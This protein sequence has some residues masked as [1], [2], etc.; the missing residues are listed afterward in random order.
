[1]NTIPKVQKVNS[2]FLKELKRAPRITT[3]AEHFENIASGKSLKPQI[4]VEA[5]LALLYHDKL[6]ISIYHYLKDKYCKFNEHCYASIPYVLENGIRIMAATH[7]YALYLKNNKNEEDF[8]IFEAGG[9]AGDI[10][11]TL[12]EISQGFI[13][14]LCSSATKANE[15][16]FNK[17]KTHLNSFFYF[18]PYFEITPELLKNSEKYSCFKNGFNLI[19]ERCT[20]QMYS[21]DRVN[22]IRILARVLKQDGIILFEEKLINKDLNEYVKGERIKD[23][24]FKIKY[25]DKFQIS[26]KKT[27]ILSAM[28][29]NQVDLQEL[30]NAIKKNFKYAALIWN[31]ANF[32]TIVASNSLH[33][34]D[35]F[36]SFFLPP[37]LPEQFIFDSNLPRNLFG[38]EKITLNFR[39]P[40]LDENLL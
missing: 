23:E 36:I 37:C 20:F 30:S 33:N 2:K 18:G 40:Y 17:I 13:K 9:G 19:Y 24:M 12:P 6:A 39:K 21:K 34:L 28:E 29:K 1:M 38:I 15:V 22:Q 3:L 11:R 5:D 7:L 27:N 10:S 35:K 8:N 31:S 25:F 26:E 16:E 32:Y 4:K 14:S